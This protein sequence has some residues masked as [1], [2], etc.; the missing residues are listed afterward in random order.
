M[1][2]NVLWRHEAFYKINSI[3]TFIIY[4]HPQICITNHIF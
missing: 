4:T 3:R 1:D 2:Q